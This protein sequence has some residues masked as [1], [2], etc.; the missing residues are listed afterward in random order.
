MKFA[1]IDVAS[2]KHFIAVMDE[3][4]TVLV[5]PTCFT[6]D[7]E[8][9]AK[10]F[11]LLGPATEVAVVVMEATGH[12]WKN[13]AAALLAKNYQVALINPL[14]TRRFAE[15]DLTRTKTDAIDALGIA[16]FAAQKRVQPSRLPN[17]ITDELRELVGL[18][19]RLMQDFGDRLRQLH[20]AVDLGFPE[21]TKHVALKT[22]LATSILK[23]YPTAAAFQG[24]RP[25]ALSNL[26]YD[27]RHLVG[28][29]L[30]TELIQAAKSSVGQHHGHPYRMQVVYFCEDLELL[31]RRLRELDRD[32]D[33]RVDQHEIAKLLT[34]IDGIGSGTAARVVAR[35]GNPA[36]FRD[37]SA[38][39]AYVGVVPSLRHSGKKQPARAPLTSIGNAELRRA[40]YLPTM[41]AVRSNPWLK[42]F[43]D[44]LVFNQK[45]KK[46]AL[47]AAM[48]KLIHAI[49]SV[50]KNRKP[51]VPVL[52]EVT[53]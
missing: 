7:A 35:V 50:A 33:T 9:Y 8:G 51:F 2:E 30:A 32:I 12:Y 41:T 5:R 20:R 23:K 38:L 52:P 43:Y 45:P 46:L 22:E 39:A 26:K 27:G 24:V 53:A 48:R 42:A 29:E 6:E 11:E 3:A 16:R 37:G 25:K 1:G 47:L 18:R 44:R 40:L 21:F 49:Y 36:D 15:T 14:R 31:R 34:T 28:L 10:L 4:E 19:D 17:A 13:L